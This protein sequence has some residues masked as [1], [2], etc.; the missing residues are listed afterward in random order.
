MGKI[1]LGNIIGAVITA[2]VV[3]AALYFTGGLALSA[4]AWWGAGAGA[5]SLVSTAMMG[6]LAKT[7][8]TPYSDVVQS[9][10]R[11]VSNATGL[12]VIYGGQMPHRN[13]VS[14]GSFVMTGSINT[15]SSVYKDS[16]QFFFSEQVV[17]YTGTEKHIE[18]LYFD[19]EPVLINPIKEDGVVSADN[20]ISK[21]RSYLQ[22]E[23]RFGGNY[24]TTKTLPKK[25]AGDKWKDTFLSK[26]VVSISVVIKKTQS[27]TENN[28]LV[29]DKFTLNCE[30]KGQKIYDFNTKT[31]VASSDPPSIIYDYLTNNIYGMGIDPNLIDQDSFTAASAYCKTNSFYANGAINYQSSFKENVELILQAFGGIMGV[32]SGR[33]TISL[34]RVSLPVASFDESNCFGTINVTTSGNTDYFNTIDAKYKN[35]ASGSRYQEDVLRIPSDISKDD[36]I[37]SDGQV[38]T[39]SRDYSWVYDTS[40]IT[41]LVNIEV[42][43]AKYSLR[44]IS[45]TTNVGADL[46]VWDTFNFS[47]KE[48]GV[49]GQFKVLSKEFSTSQDKMGYVTITGVETNAG[50]YNGTD[51][52][53]FSPGG[54]IVSDAQIVMPPSNLQ[55]VRKGTLT[56]GSYVTMSWTAS[57]DPYLRGY[58]VFSRKTGETTW[59]VLGTTD[60]YRLSFDILNLNDVDSYDFAVCAYNNLGLQSQYVTLSGLVPSYNFTLPAVTGVNL[61][62][63]TVSALVTD[64]GDFNIAWDSQKN[65][66]VNGKPFAEF[67]KYYVVKV[68]DGTKLVDTL[69]TDNNIFNYTYE[70]NTNKIRKP[71]FG[72]TA[73]GFNAGTYSAEVKITV[74]NKQC[75]Q[76]TNVSVSGGFGNMFVEWGKSTERDYAGALISVASPVKTTVYTSTADQF[77]TVK[78]TDGEYKVKVGFYDIFGTDNIFYSPEVTVSIKSVYN[79]DQADADAIN[80]I[81]NLDNRFQETVQASKDYSNTQLDVA[82]GYADGQMQEAIKEAN[83]NTATVVTATKTQIT[84]ETNTKISASETKLSTQVANGDTALQQ[85]INLTNASVGKN[86]ADIT[87]LTKNVADNN[88]ASSTQISNLQTS[89]T[90]TQNDLNSTNTKLGTVENTAN[91]AATKSSLAETNNKVSGIDTRVT[92]N[93]TNITNLNQAVSTQNSAN[94]TRF[95]NIESSVTNVTNTANN[96]ATKGDLTNTNTIVTRH[97]S[98]I[99]N[100]QTTVASNDSVTTENIN[101]LTAAFNQTEGNIVTNDSFEIGSTNSA[102]GWN[103]YNGSNVSMTLTRPAGRVQGVAVQ[104]MA[105]ASTSSTHGINSTT[106]IPQFTQGQTYVCSFFAKKVNG[107]GFTRCDMGFSGTVPTR[108]TILNPEL[109]TSWQRYAF[110]F[111]WEG[112]NPNIVRQLQITRSGTSVSG[113]AIVIDDVSVTLGS[114][115]MGYTRR[116]DDGA[117]SQIIDLSSAFSDANSSNASR[118]T[119]IESSVTSVNTKATNADTKATNA[120]SA[121]A[122]ADTKAS[123][124]KSAADAAQTTANTANTQAQTNKASIS[125]LQT[126]VA[127]NKQAAADQTTQLRTEMNNNVGTINTSLST[128]ADKDTV[129]SSYSLSVNANGT[130]AGFKL[131]ANAGA[132]NNSAIYFAADKFIVSGT[133]AATVGGTA[134]FAIVNGTTYLKTAM[135]QL[136]SI[137]TAFIADAAI[138]TSKIGALQ[139][140]RACIA[141]ASI[142]SIKLSGIIQS[143]NFVANT[144]GWQFT[145]S[146]DLLINGTGGTGRMSIHNNLIQ[147]FDNNGTLRVRMG[148]W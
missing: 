122:T 11:S 39:L 60:V 35:T 17:A 62:N 86:T 121:A 57:E 123:N 16:S 141:D 26:G 22:L 93:S 14:G 82:K 128:K 139:V 45:F 77:D 85:Q 108:T 83:S 36:V 140:T 131:L 87:N 98:E 107:A 63:K 9:L 104:V 76:A 133:S 51:P 30:M 130:V 113:D 64:S 47:N 91:N 143:D 37:R 99:S 32:H 7:G 1:G 15:W 101:R 19:N 34:D 81:L 80:S 73:Q 146:G 2:V 5:L 55:V 115:L 132:A 116:D 56:T 66:Q 148:L 3:A 84:N 144:S 147:I 92:T 100:L 59:S 24:T 138:T 13:G 111:V 118:F 117:R 112:T 136:A 127:D 95:Q 89:V 53:V 33:I 28:V 106:N 68:Y 25:Y 79:Y 43:K 58:R 31:T 125:G 96:S 65:I 105:N 114:E 21:F 78:V 109:T 124:A 41:K 54:S 126:T 6:T 48:T 12:P 119:S 72:I 38:I 135:I 4:A 110:R 42:L 67:F 49:S 75:V 102:T 94:A 61:T 10:S 40:T 145:K 23:V 27:S 46:K 134:P 103:I 88:T 50:I 20:I 142:D 129:N 90:K 74:E 52:G 69:Y 71:T 18:Q 29:N 137:G 120:A 8:V 70:M 97:T 44:T